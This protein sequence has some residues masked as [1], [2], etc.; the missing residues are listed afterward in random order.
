MLPIALPCRLTRS[1]IRLLQITATKVGLNSSGAFYLQFSLRRQLRIDCWSPIYLS[2]GRRPA[3][4]HRKSCHSAAHRLPRPSTDNCRNIARGLSAPGLDYC[5]SL[6]H[7]DC[8][9]LSTELQA[10][11]VPLSR[12]ATREIRIDKVGATDMV[13]IGR[14]R[15]QRTFENSRHWWMSSCLAIC[16][17]L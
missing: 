13:A 2:L 15:R 10:T 1:V 3:R 7:G 12:V 8:W 11:S 4:S 5:N 14:G 9:Q 6:L 17:P 16:S